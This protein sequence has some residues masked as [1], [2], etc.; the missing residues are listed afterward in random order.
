M[1]PSE[2][3]AQWSRLKAHFR[4]GSDINP[5]EINAEWFAQLKHLHV[6]A[7]DAGMTV[8]I[9]ASQD[10]FFPALGAL[11]DAIRTRMD[12]YDKTKGQCETCHG[13]TW[14]TDRPFWVGPFLY[15]NVVRRCPDCGVPAP[16]IKEHRFPERRELTATE[17][18]HYLAGELKGQQM[19]PPKPNHDA[20]EALRALRKKVAPFTKFEKPEGL[21]S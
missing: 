8:L 7:V 3:N 9:G 12:R 2:W 17:Y 5:A 20:L 21:A 14:V 16:S 10:T 11:K 15:E 4:L 19:T 1:T 13:S 18:A 6:D